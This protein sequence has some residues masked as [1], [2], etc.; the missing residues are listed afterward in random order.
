MIYPIDIVLIVML[1]AIGVWAID[2]L[3]GSIR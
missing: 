3:V 1:I 2:K